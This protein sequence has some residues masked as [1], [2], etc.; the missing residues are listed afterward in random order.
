[1]E[2]LNSNGQYI[3]DNNRIGQ[4]IR[5]ARINQKITQENLSETLDLTPAFIGH[6]ERGS[7][8]VSLT[9]LVC[10][11]NVLNIP[12]HYF[13]IDKNFTPDEKAVNAFVQLTEG[14][15]QKT[16]DAVLDIIRTALTHLD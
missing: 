14:R 10:I 9:T 4:I 15:P 7:R 13:F 6:I 3:V 16:K 11:A 5:E 12:I 8:S 2:I 1:M